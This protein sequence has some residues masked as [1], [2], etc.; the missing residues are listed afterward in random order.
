VYSLGLCRYLAA[1]SG[2]RYRGPLLL[3]RPCLCQYRSVSVEHL[4]VRVHHPR[5]PE[6]SRVTHRH[7]MGPNPQCLAGT[8]ESG[9]SH[10]ES[11]FSLVFQHERTLVPQ[12]WLSHPFLPFH[13]G[14]SIYHGTSWTLCL[15]HPLPQSIPRI[16][17]SPFADRFLAHKILLSPRLF[18]RHP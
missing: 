15:S 4:T 1:L 13:P 7:S 6:A 8:S 9:R 10:L 11:L 2:G 17:R 14:H 5:S 16:H 18:A 12:I 3:E